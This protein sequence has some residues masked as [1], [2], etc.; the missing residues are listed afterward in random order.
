VCGRHPGQGLPARGKRSAHDLRSKEAT[1]DCTHESKSSA[2]SGNQPGGV[3]LGSPAATRDQAVGTGSRRGRHR[4]PGFLLD[5][6]GR[7]FTW[8]GQILAPVI[9]QRRL[10]G[11]MHDYRWR[12]NGRTFDR[13]VPLDVRQ[14][15]RV[16][17]A[18]RQPQHD[19]SPMHLHSHTF[20]VR[21][22]DRRPGPRKTASC[23]TS[24]AGRPL[25]ACR[26]V[27]PRGSG[28]GRRRRQP[29]SGR[30]RTTPARHC[31]R[32][33]AVPSPP[34]RACRTPGR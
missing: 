26:L 9:P 20:Q 18:V 14:G 5:R 4:F 24:T 19:D 12:T 27:W 33:A 23:S 28:A 1:A 25:M 34:T 2:S 31:C 32:G 8:V 13:A 30:S 11:R 16:L 7:P 6:P 15:Q 22:A 3:S 17:V 10:E 21:R 29:R